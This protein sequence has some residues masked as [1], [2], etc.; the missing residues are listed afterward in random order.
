MCFLGLY[1]KQTESEK[2]LY[3]PV[4]LTV[5]PECSGKTAFLQRSQTFFLLMLTVQAVYQSGLQKNAVD[6]FSISSIN[7]STVQIRQLLANESVL[8]PS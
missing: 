5:L 3:A 8:Y 2:H 6:F 1:K 7:S 4:Y